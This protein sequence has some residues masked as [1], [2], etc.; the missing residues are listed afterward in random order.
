MGLTQRGVAATL[1]AEGVRTRSGGEWRH[2]YIAAF[3]R[4]DAHA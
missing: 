1:N 3:E 2:Q 4:V